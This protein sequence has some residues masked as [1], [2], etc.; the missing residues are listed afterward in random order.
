MMPAQAAQLQRSGLGA[1]SIPA[2]IPRNEAM[3]CRLRGE[4]RDRR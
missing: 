4:V 3:V 2:T 1:P